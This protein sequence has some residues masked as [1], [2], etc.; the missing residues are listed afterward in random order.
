MAKDILVIGIILYPTTVMMAAVQEETM[1]AKAI[2]MT[3][4]PM[5][6][7]MTANLTHIRREQVRV[8]A[9]I[10]DMVKAVHTADTFIAGKKAKILINII[11]K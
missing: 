4:V 2:I 9:A 3:I 5:T 8:I 6:V 7:A 10:A 11:T 1:M